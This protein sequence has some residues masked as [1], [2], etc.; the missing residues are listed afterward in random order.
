[1]KIERK[2]LMKALS[3]L[4]P[5]IGKGEGNFSS[6]NYTFMVDEEGH[7]FIG[8]TNNSVAV[9]KPISF[10]FGCT[11]R[12]SGN[13][14]FQLVKKLKAQEIEVDLSDEYMRLRT[15]STESMVQLAPANS[16]NLLDMITDI[17][18]EFFMPLPDNFTEALQECA[19]FTSDET[20]QPIL[21]YVYADNNKMCSANNAEIVVHYLN[22]TVS[23]MFIPSNDLTN[24]KG[25]KLTH[26]VLKG[27]FLYFKTEDGAFIIMQPASSKERYPVVITPEDFCD[28]DL[29]GAY[30]AFTMESLFNAEG[31][32]E[33]VFTDDEVKALVETVQACCLFAD[34]EKQSVTC[35]FDGDYVDF[36][37]VDDK[38]SHKQ[39][40]K[41]SS[42]VSPFSIRIKPQPF[43]DL[44]T[45]RDKLFV[46]AGK[47]IV[48]NDNVKH[49]IQVR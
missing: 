47:V 28:T 15:D 3:T 22:G 36:K 10:S 27:E 30:K 48:S 12:V 26:Y 19:K 7:S 35:S 1:M 18:E 9:I 17:P 2:E 25:F 39:R 16:N 29:K 31:M 32:R 6:N 37:G 24:I 33:L 42:F 46:G 14:L 11:C 41:L 43:I 21:Q 13:T 34:E 45:R 40:V 20:R 8:A 38:G 23:K 44:I 4:Y 49:L 5:V